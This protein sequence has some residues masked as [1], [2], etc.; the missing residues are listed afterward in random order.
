M[1]PYTM[2]IIVILFTECVFFHSKNL[3]RTI[4]F[5]YLPNILFDNRIKLLNNL[6]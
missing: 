6:Y 3:I 4:D 1:C 2:L 5:V